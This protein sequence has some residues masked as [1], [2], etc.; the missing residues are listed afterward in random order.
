[1][2]LCL[3]FFFS[4]G[5]NILCLSVWS[6]LVLQFCYDNEI[7]K[8]HF[9]LILKNINKYFYNKSLFLNVNF[10]SCKEYFSTYLAIQF[11]WSTY[12]AIVVP[13]YKFCPYSAESLDVS[14]VNL[15]VEINY[16]I[17]NAATYNHWSRLCINVI[18]FASLC[19]KVCL[20]LHQWN[21]FHLKSIWTQ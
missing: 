13:Y 1:M 4:F 15:M 5:I 7:K 17:I 20:V 14:L 9:N 21:W 18:P 3:I 10:I 6:S 8:N 12:V 16:W 19:G 2:I 11:K